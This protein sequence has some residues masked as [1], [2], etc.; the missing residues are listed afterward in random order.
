MLGVVWP[1]SSADIREHSFHESKHLSSCHWL[2]FSTLT[3][4]GLTVFAARSK[5]DQRLTLL[6]LHL[7][8]EDVEQVGQLEDQKVDHVEIG[9][10][11][12]HK[13]ELS[14]RLLMTLQS[15]GAATHTLVRNV[16]CIRHR[17]RESES[18]HP[19]HNA[20]DNQERRGQQNGKGLAE[21]PK[22]FFTHVREHHVHD[23]LGKT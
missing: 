10:E 11:R 22:G 4:L 14:N 21:E 8:D 12:E 3:V 16:Q 13:E 23:H 19:R 18:T 9:A 5:E 7:E 15:F 1:V 6:L 20:D 2:T 17:K